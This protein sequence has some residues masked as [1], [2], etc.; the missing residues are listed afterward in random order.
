VLGTP[1]EA[2]EHADELGG[3]R[4]KTRVDA[5]DVDAHDGRMQATGAGITYA[6]ED[7]TF[8]ST[9]S[10]GGSDRR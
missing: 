4:Q 5:G 9:S 2:V 3:R 10:T 8:R 6:L 7:L 1:G